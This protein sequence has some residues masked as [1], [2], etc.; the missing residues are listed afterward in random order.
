MEESP[1][2]TA[3][4][5]HKK[6]N[7]TTWFFAVGVVGA[8]F[9]GEDSEFRV[10]ALLTVLVLLGLCFYCLMTVAKIKAHI[11][12]EEFQMVISRY[13]WILGQNA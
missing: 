10:L 7:T 12:Q 13:G 8:V 5:I 1:A 4:R 6:W 11:A 2:E 9:V 3:S